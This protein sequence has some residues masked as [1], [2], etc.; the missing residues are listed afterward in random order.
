MLKDRNI[1]ARDVKLGI[2]LHII[3]FT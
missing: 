1:D 2:K 3:V